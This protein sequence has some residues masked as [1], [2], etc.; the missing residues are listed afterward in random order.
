M[1]KYFK[2]LKTE[3]DNVCQHCH[4]NEKKKGE[5]V[6]GKC[7]KELESWRNKKDKKKHESLLEYVIGGKLTK[8]QQLLLD[9]YNKYI[10]II[11]R[12][13]SSIIHIYKSLNK[14]LYRGFKD[15][16][17][18]DII[19]L[20]WRTTE[21]VEQHTT[22]ETQRAINAAFLEKFGWKVRNGIFVSTL[23]SQTS[24]YGSPYIFFPVNKFQFCYSPTIEDLWL[25]MKVQPHGIS[26]KDWKIKRQEQFKRLVNRHTDKNLQDAWNRE[27]EI[28][29]K[30]PKYYLVSTKYNHMLTYSL[31]MKQGIPAAPRQKSKDI[32]SA[33]SIEYLA[34]FLSKK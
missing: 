2:Y 21:R 11:K 14:F 23:Y 22:I 33:L 31:G 27:G 4:K 28:S 6:C 13:C 19:E 18:R 3:D 1:E 25:N 5:A 17:N 29:F 9:N 12:D 7:S 8:N 34:S 26:N 15:P 10:E 24:I 32:P 20:K 30:T 16:E